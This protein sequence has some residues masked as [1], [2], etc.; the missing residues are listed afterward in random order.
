MKLIISGI[1]CFVLI[2]VFVL[3][4]RTPVIKAIQRSNQSRFKLKNYKLYCDGIFV[5]VIDPGKTEFWAHS[6]PD[7][8]S[9]YSKEDNEK[10]WVQLYHKGRTSWYS[11]DD[12][13]HLI[14]HRDWQHA[15]ITFNVIHPKIA[16]NKK[17]CFFIGIQ[18]AGPLPDAPHL[19]IT[20]HEIENLQP[21]WNQDQ[22]FEY[23]LQSD[24]F[25]IGEKVY[26]M[27]WFLSGA[28]AKTF[29]VLSQEF[30][31]VGRWRY[32]YDF[33]DYV[34]TN[35]NPEVAIDQ[36]SIYFGLYKSKHITPEG[37]ELLNRNYFR[38]QDFI[39]YFSPLNREEPYQLGTAF[40]STSFKALCSYYAKDKNGVYVSGGTHK[41]TKGDPASFVSLGEGYGFDKNQVF[42]NS[43][44]IENAEVK[45]FSV[46]GR[47]FSKDHREVF[48]QAYPIKGA[49]PETFELVMPSQII[50]DYLAN[51]ILR[52]E[53]G[54]QFA[55]DKNSVFHRHKRLTKNGK[56]S[57]D[58][59][60]YLSDLAAT[61]KQLESTRSRKFKY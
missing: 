4:Y 43:V 22:F 19:S 57:F 1:I 26:Y 32:H 31:P 36:K 6:Q 39:Y 9:I 61:Q 47:E 24:Y 34:W 30:E 35:S 2:S 58:F 59:F 21:N 45:S 48:F 10:K 54:F 11:V 55:T 29:R 27:S 37:F 49:D 52:V 53:T 23:D 13:L 28:D 15:D 12:R 51:N 50:Q 42:Y 17:S 41:M 20:F 16:C 5:Q 3:M 38:F 8:I 25:K 33:E 56:E 44:A 60:K 7:F 14:D 40:D 46:I 18:A